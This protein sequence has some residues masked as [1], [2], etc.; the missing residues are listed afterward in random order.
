MSTDLS[1][2]ASGSVTVTP[3][4]DS[5]SGVADDYTLSTPSVTLN[6]ANGFTATITVTAVAS[7]GDEDEEMM[8]LSYTVDHTGTA[9]EVGDPPNTTLTITDGDIPEATIAPAA[10]T[11][12]EGATVGS[13]GCADGTD[14][15][16]VTVTLTIAAR[17]SGVPVM[18]GFAGTPDAATT[19]GTG[20]DFT[21]TGDTV[22]QDSSVITVTVPDGETTA[23]F[24]VT[25]LNDTDDEAGG[26]LTF[27]LADPGNND[28]ALGTAQTSVITITDNDVPAVADGDFTATPGD[29]QVE[30]SWTNPTTTDIASVTISATDLN[31]AVDINGTE[32]GN[33]LSVTTGITSG[34]ISMVT[35]TEGMVNGIEY[36]F[37][38]VVLDSDGNMSASCCTTPVTATPIDNV[39]PGDVTNQRAIPGNTQV[40]LSW[41]N[42]AD[43][44]LASVTISAIVTAT[45]APV[46]I[47][48]AGTEGETV[49][50][51]SLTPGGMGT[52][53]ITEGL[54]NGTGYTFSIVTVDSS[55]NVSTPP[56]TIEATPTLLTASV[57]ITP[58]GGNPGTIATV[59]E[60]VTTASIVT[61][62]LN[63]TGSGA[64]TLDVVFTGSASELCDTVNRRASPA[65]GTATATCPDNTLRLGAMPFT[66]GVATFELLP[67]SNEVYND[68]KSYTF[69]LM[70]TDD[71]TAHA[72][73][74]TVTFNIE[75]DD[76]SAITD[77]RA[78]GRDRQ[79]ILIW[80]NPA[81][82]DLAFV[83]ISATVTTGGAS[84]NLGA[85]TNADPGGVVVPE[86]GSDLVPTVTPGPGSGSLSALIP[87]R[88]YRITTTG[89]SNG[90]GYTFTIV[91]V[92]TGNNV[93]T[94][95][96]AMVTPMIPPEASIAVTGNATITESDINGSCTAT[97]TT[98]CTT[99]TVSLNEGR[100][101]G[102]GCSDGRSHCGWRV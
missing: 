54:S 5:G 31:G 74:N 10:R 52:A 35:I 94:A 1:D 92:D 62:T 88:G 49:S 27:T 66:D 39:A 71:Y 68:D 87:G 44:D 42:P 59:A 100:S 47:N 50:V 73:A 61:V 77:F 45:E 24:T 75:D 102:R 2:P 95:Q 53:T 82:A 57:T 93:S 76:V 7:D 46:D 69:T 6:M 9:D 79:A 19:I 25:V 15:V 23:S 86:S 99:V 101:H 81:D 85:L 3:M 89:L 91:A 20:N 65:V 97:M 18:I 37:S 21:V 32:A 83:R 30:L 4:Y 90:T 43:A 80:T 64:S 96:T 40:V 28:Y 56:V 67:V 48:G 36:T 38:I 17:P 29:V 58:P 14:C 41:T 55:S 22:T 72:T 63:P 26:S 70:S 11:L 16:E 84:V 51:T 12:A 98:N 33:D 78:V 8:V 34:M 13:P 60:S